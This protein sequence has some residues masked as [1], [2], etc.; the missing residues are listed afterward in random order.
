M[1]HYLPTVPEKAGS[2]QPLVSKA[3]GKHVTFEEMLS[4]G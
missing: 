3:L 4:W 1:F 2:L